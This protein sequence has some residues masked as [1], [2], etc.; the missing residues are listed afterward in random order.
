MAWVHAIYGKFQK[1]LNTFFVRTLM[2]L[3]CL[4]IKVTNGIVVLVANIFA[5]IVLKN[6]T[7]SV[8]LV[9]KEQ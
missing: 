9:L 7:G 1:H 4:L 2:R 5:K 6:T 3:L 8:K